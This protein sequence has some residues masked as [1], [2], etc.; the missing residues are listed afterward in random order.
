M[1]IFRSNGKLLITGEYLILKGALSLAVPVNYGQSLELLPAHGSA[2]FD[3]HTYQNDCPIFR[4][5]FDPDDLSIIDTNSESMAQYLRNILINASQLTRINEPF[6]NVK[7]ITR[8]NF[9]I[10]WGLGSSS[11]LIS[12]IAGWLGIEPFDLFFKVSEGSGYDVA[13]ARSQ[14]PIV[15][16]IKKGRPWFRQVHFSPPFQDKIFFIYLGKKQDSAKSVR[17]FISNSRKYSSEIKRVSQI[18]EEILKVRD[19]NQFESLLSEHEELIA[20]IIK[21]TPVKSLNFPDFPGEIKSLGAWGGDFILA[22][23]RKGEKAVDDYFRKKKLETIFTFKE[24]VKCE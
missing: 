17:S 3:W 18:S 12:N 6:K 7:I 11:S 4:C 14:N 19:L 20:H 23:C 5:D 16:K 9:N 15:Y 10:K 1:Q 22:T 13:C 2:C 24:M 21:E 8:L